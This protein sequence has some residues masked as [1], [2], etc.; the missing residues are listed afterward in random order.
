M[1]KH[2][3][4]GDSDKETINQNDN[5]PITKTMTN[6]TTKELTNKIINEDRLG[7]VITSLDP[8]KAAGPDNIQN[9]LIQN[10]YKYIK[11]PL[12]RLYKQSHN[13]GYIPKPWRETKGIFLPKPGEVDYNDAKSYRT[14]TLSSNFLKIHERLILWFMEHDLG[15]D[16]TLNKKQYGF[17]KGCSTEAAL[18]KI[19]HIIE[20]RIKKKGYVLGTFLDI[21]GA[22]DNISFNAIKTTLQNSKIDSVTCNWIYN[23]ISNRFTTVSLKHSTKRFKITK[24]CP[25]GGVLS[26]VLWNM[27]V[28]NLL[29]KRANEIPGYLQ[30][31]ADDCAILVERNNLAVIHGRTQ[32]SINSINRWCKNNG[33]N[34]SSLKTKIIMFTWRR[35]W[36]LPKDLL[37][38]G[39]TIDLSHSIKFLGIHLDTKLSFNE[40]IKHITKK[41]TMSLMQCKRAIGP[42]WGLSPGSCKLIYE[43]AIRPILSY[44]SLVWIN[45]LHRKHNQNAL[46]KVE[47]L[48]LRMTSGAMPSTPTIALNQ[49]TN[50]KFISNYREGEAVKSLLRVKAACHLTRENPEARKGDI[51]P[52]TYT[53]NQYINKL[54]LSKSDQDLIPKQL[55]LNKSFITCKKDRTDAINFVDQVKTDDITIYTDGSGMNG[56]LGYGYHISTNKNAT[57]ISEGSGRLPDFC[58]V[59][60]AE[61]MAISPACEKLKEHKL[62]NK[63]IYILSDSCSAINA[64]NKRVINSATIFDCLGIIDELAADNSITMCWV[65]GHCNVPGNE[66]ADALARRGVEGKTHIK[67]YIP[68]S[69]TKKT[70]NSKVYADSL[71]I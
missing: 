44:G 57:K 16:N 33:L 66:M 47:R 60:Q 61:V 51:T 29:N 31:F 56:K 36:K 37:L 58:T 62:I 21:E 68:Y 64:L 38:D 10:A 2:H 39:K 59:F 43:K 19:V 9:V 4:T 25:Q 42:T 13:I 53:I 65:P 50:P 22:F 12:L 30:A 71:Y 63:N 8:L 69:Y 70:I 26:P 24:G 18:H 41:A 20:R 17:R 35:K 11:H 6:K 48:A 55:H 49:L 15:L 14:I 1:I 23:M 40:H 27:V 67:A 34:I 3:F 52:H 7:K 5:Q 45:A 54:N 28:D 32:K 46:A